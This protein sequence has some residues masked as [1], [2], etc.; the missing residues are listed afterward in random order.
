M[1]SSLMLLLE[2]V[3]NFSYEATL[4]LGIEKVSDCDEVF[5]F[6]TTMT[7][8]VSLLRAETYTLLVGSFVASTR[9]PG[10]PG[11]RAPTRVKFQSC[12]MFGLDGSNENGR[13]DN[14]SLL[15][16]WSVWGQKNSF[17]SAA[18]EATGSLSA[19]TVR[20]A[21]VESG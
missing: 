16:T 1:P 3:V 13:T 8:S 20:T 2:E 6:T 10:G 4:V 18:R 7:T 19:G 5:R 14:V 12:W 11:R 21:T 9:S 17:F 15:D